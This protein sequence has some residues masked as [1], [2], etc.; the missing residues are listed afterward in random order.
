MSGTDSVV[1]LLDDNG[2]V[3]ETIRYLLESADVRVETFA[4]AEEFFQ[5]RSS[6]GPASLMFDVRLP[7]MSGP[8]ALRAL[9]R[10]GRPLPTIVITG[11][12]DVPMFVEA[13]RA[14]AIGFLLEPLRAEELLDAIHQALSE[15]AVARRQRRELADLKRRYASLTPREREVMA[16]VVCG[17][18]NKQIAGGLGTSQATIK[19]HRAHV[20]RKMQV[21]SVAELARIGERL[22]L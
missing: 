18:L 10:P 7:G 21:R 3:R 11:H 20:M 8:D 22:G 9:Q 4:N 16:G 6:D 19:M 15:A 5:R 12:G 1:F 2:S 13:M 14:G 17:R